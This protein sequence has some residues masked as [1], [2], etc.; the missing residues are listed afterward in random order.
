M[1]RVTFPPEEFVKRSIQV[2]HSGATAVWG[3]PFS[4][5]DSFSGR[6]K[7]VIPVV[8]SSVWG[9]PR[10]NST[11]NS[12]VG[13]A[14]LARRP[15]EAV[16]TN[17]SFQGNNSVRSTCAFL[18]SPED[19]V[20]RRIQAGHCRGNSSVGRAGSRQK[21]REAGDTGASSQLCLPQCGECLEQGQ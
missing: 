9:V 14:L 10:H 21:I 5:E 16:E 4:P 19:F 8:L 2:G 17:R 18:F 3:V 7:Q 15:R 13:S 11:G 1:W 12:S 20:K 6:Y